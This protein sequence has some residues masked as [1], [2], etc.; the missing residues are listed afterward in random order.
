MFFKCA[1]SKSA[2]LLMHMLKNAEHTKKLP[3]LRET[4]SFYDIVREYHNIVRII[5]IISEQFR[6]GTKKATKPTNLP[7]CYLSLEVLNLFAIGT[8]YLE[9]LKIPFILTL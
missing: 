4:S 2:I 8:W 1:G 3:L 9:G 6:G 5:R 7:V